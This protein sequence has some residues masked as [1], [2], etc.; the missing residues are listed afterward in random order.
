MSHQECSPS[1][2]VA[3]H[4][5]GDLKNVLLWLLGG[6]VWSGVAFRG[7]C[8][9][10]PNLLASV[11]LLWSWSDEGTLHQRFF[12]ARR[13]AVFLFPGQAEPATTYQAFLKIL[14][15]RLRLPNRKRSRPL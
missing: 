14:R 5:A 9:W 1:K 13:I 12:A 4:R 3:G 2:P 8:T 6:V 15:R 7:D 10:T 11:S